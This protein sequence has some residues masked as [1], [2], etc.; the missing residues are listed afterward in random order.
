EI[1]WTEPD[2][3]LIT[4]GLTPNERVVISRIATPVPNMLLRTAEPDSAAPPLEPSAPA[5]QAGP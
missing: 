5:A 3:V 4:G 2:S 1:A